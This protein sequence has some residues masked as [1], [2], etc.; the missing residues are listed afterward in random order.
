[1]LSYAINKQEFSGKTSSVVLIFSI[2]TTTTYSKFL[3][4][5]CIR[6]KYE[7]HVVEIHDYLLSLV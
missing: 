4:A 3:K 1:M 2:Q 7:L 6:E 5:R